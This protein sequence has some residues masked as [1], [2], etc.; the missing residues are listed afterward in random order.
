M[1]KAI[2]IGVMD[3]LDKIWI[4]KEA[5]DCG[6]NEIEPLGMDM[7]YTIFLMMVIALAV[8]LVLLGCEIFFQRM[9]SGTK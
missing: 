9:T 2:E 7:L 1:K 3:K 6:I 5:Q 4:P 8:C